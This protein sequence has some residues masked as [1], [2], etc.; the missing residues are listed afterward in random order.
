MQTIRFIDLFCG[1]G[2]FRYG[3]E[4]ANE[5]SLQGGRCENTQS[6]G[7][8]PIVGSGDIGGR[9]NEQQTDGN[10]SKVKELQGQPKCGVDNIE[11]SQGATSGDSK[12]GEESYSG[13]KTKG[14]QPRE[15]W[16]NKRDNVYDRYNGQ[17]ISN[18]ARFQCVWSNDF[19]K[20]ACQIY[21]Y[22]FGEIHEGDIRA[23]DADRLPDCDLITFGWPCQDNSVAGK[24]A[25]MGDNTRS[26]LLV[27]A[28]RIL[29]VKKPRYFIAENVPGLFSVNKGLDFYSAI[30]MFT[31]IGYDVQWQVLDTRWFLPQNRERI[32][33]VGHI[34]GEPQPQIFPIGEGCGKDSK[35]LRVN[36]CTRPITTVY[37]HSSGKYMDFVR[38]DSPQM[39]SNVYGGFGENE[40]RL[41]ED[42]SPTIRTPKGGGHLPMVIKRHRKDE[43]RNHGGV[44]PTIGAAMGTSGGN[45]PMIVRSAAIRTRAYRGDP[46]SLEVR[47]DEVSNAIDSVQK[48]SLVVQ[49]ARWVR[50]EEGKEA[51]KQSKLTTGVDTTPFSGGAR[52]LVPSEDNSIGCITGAINKDSLVF[53]G[54]V[55]EHNRGDGTLSRDYSKQ[56]RVYSAEGVAETLPSQDRYMGN[57]L[58]GK[59]IRRL[60]PMEC[61][62]LQGFPDLFTALGVTQDGKVV[63]ISDTQRYKVCGNAVSTPVVTEIGVRLLNFIDKKNGL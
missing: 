12:Q 42:I 27:E 48:D 1:I 58:V 10:Q 16:E 34:R 26:G 7:S 14:T 28:I 41:H 47:N 62:R 56:D 6:N 2:G 11:R 45:T 59:S 46:T 25:G 21:R 15:G 31:D 43:I 18:G 17:E 33:F 32:Y 4:K 20:Y 52:E 51:R 60:T 57:Y 3:L 23:V 53:V 24:R 13:N 40:P 54:G 5:Y 8:M 30:R 29:R 44:S 49:P 55:D 19:D 39:I 61:E 63:N 37:A 22:Q 38:Q 35:I 9:W 36:N 50:T